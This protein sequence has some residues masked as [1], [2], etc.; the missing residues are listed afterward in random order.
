MNVLLLGAGHIGYT[1][2]QLLHNTG[3]YK[4]L[5]ADRDKNS[6][7]AIAAL[8][9]AT[10][11]VDSADGNALEAAMQGQDAVLNALPYHMAIGVAKAAK[12]TGTHYF[13]LT[14]DVHATKT[15]RELAEGSATAFMPQCG[16]APGCIGIAAH[17]LA[18]HF[19]SVREVK[20]RVGALP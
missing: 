4:V 8:G 2:A 19:D 20:M 14:E 7:K 3:D 6:L 5:V 12:A 18:Q 16:L 15:I 9:I 13:D 1:I 17:S 10:R 11:E